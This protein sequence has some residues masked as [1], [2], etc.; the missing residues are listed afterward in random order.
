MPS[1][2]SRSA[3]SPQKK[4]KAGEKKTEPRKK[5]VV[6]LRRID[7]DKDKAEEGRQ[8]RS[9]RRSV[10]SQRDENDTT[11]NEIIHSTRS[12]SRRSRGAAVSPVA[13]P[14]R[15]STRIQE[16]KSRS[17]SAGTKPDQ[18]SSRQA[19]TTRTKKGDLPAPPPVV[20]KEKVVPKKTSR[21]RKKINLGNTDE[22]PTP[23][24]P[25][26]SVAAI[27]A[28]NTERSSPTLQ[29]ER[30]PSSSFPQVPST[31][32][33]TQST[34]SSSSSSESTQGPSSLQNNLESRTATSEVSSGSTTSS[35]SSVVIALPRIDLFPLLTD[36][37]VVQK[38]KHKDLPRHLQSIMS[39]VFHEV[40]EEDAS[41]SKLYSRVEKLYNCAEVYGVDFFVDRYHATF[42]H[43][44]WM[45]T[46]SPV[47]FKS[48]LPANKF[49]IQIWEFL[50]YC[51]VRLG[52]EMETE[53]GDRNKQK[54]ILMK[55]PKSS[56]YEPAA[57]Y[58]VKLF[59][60][61]QGDQNPTS[62]QC[63]LKFL[64]TLVRTTSE[65]NNTNFLKY[66]ADTVSHSVTI[67]LKDKSIQC[68]L[69]AISTLSYFTRLTTID[70]RDIIK[71]IKF[72]TR[73]DPSVEVRKL[74][75]TVLA[76]TN[77]KLRF[78][79]DQAFDKSLSVRYE[80]FKAFV[81]EQD[82]ILVRDMGQLNPEKLCKVIVWGMEYS[83]TRC[84]DLMTTKILLSWLRKCC[85]NEL[86]T[87][88]ARLDAYEHMKAVM[89]ILHKMLT[90]E[91]VETL[92]LSFIESTVADV[93]KND[94]KNL[95]IE[96]MVGWQVLCS[97]S[98]R[99][100]SLVPKVIP[101]VTKILDIVKSLHQCAILESSAAEKENRSEDI[102]PV[103]CLTVALQLIKFVTFEEGNRRHFVKL[104]QE[105]L[106]D[107]LLD[108]KP[109][110]VQ[111]VHTLH[112]YVQ[113]DE[114]KDII[115]SIFQDVFD[116]KSDNVQFNGTQS[117]GEINE[118]ADA[119]VEMAEEIELNRGGD[120]EEVFQNI[121][122]EESEVPPPQ[123]EIVLPKPLT[124][125][126][127]AKLREQLCDLKSHRLDLQNQK[128]ALL[129]E[130]RFIDAIPLNQKISVVSQQE[131]EMD[132]QL[133]EAL[134]TN[135]MRTALETN[136][137]VAIVTS[138][139]INNNNSINARVSLA[140]SVV[141]NDESVDQNDGEKTE[142]EDEEDNDNNNASGIINTVEQGLVKGLCMINA[143]M[144]LIGKVDAF[145]R[146]I[147]ENHLAKFLL[148]TDVS[149]HLNVLKFLTKIALADKREL[150]KVT[151]VLIRT[152]QEPGDK[153]ELMHVS[154]QSLVDLV[155]SYD[156]KDFILTDD[157]KLEEGHL[158]PYKDDY[159]EL[160][161]D[162]LGDKT[163]EYESATVQDVQKLFT[164]MFSDK[165]KNEPKLSQDERNVLNT[166]KHQGLLKLLIRGRIRDPK[167]ISSVLELWVN[168]DYIGTPV[169]RDLDHALKLLSTFEW[170]GKDTMQAEDGNTNI[171]MHVLAESLAE[172][173]MHLS[174]EQR[175]SVTDDVIEKFVTY[176][177]GFLDTN[178]EE[179]MKY[180]TGLFLDTIH[181][182]PSR[183]Y[184][185]ALVKCAMIVPLKSH[186]AAIAVVNSINE[187]NESLKH[188]PPTTS[189]GNLKAIIKKFVA[190]IKR[191]FG[192]DVVANIRDNYSNSTSDPEDVN[193]FGDDEEEDQNQGN[194]EAEEEELKALISDTE[195]QDV[196]M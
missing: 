118:D 127:I 80:A 4:E 5:P 92:D 159:T 83:D 135:A 85:N 99:I 3:K 155:V 34:Q 37:R 146:N 6:V 111:A 41:M 166:T 31:S 50:E 156:Y 25:N 129:K 145:V 9:A 73:Y 158:H 88:L 19:T 100:P 81:V 174:Q 21:P 1:L 65:A 128:D 43:N 20:E 114:Y 195:D 117:R 149:I 119:D 14:S 115:M 170:W 123:P 16:R 8:T 39:K 75:T 84:S 152:L 165:F 22:S 164:K 60:K 193:I 179:L 154:Y 27:P 30:G 67:R 45:M 141:E 176:I 151:R 102:T 46:T 150:R 98:Q 109:L 86:P 108:E 26:I 38:Q 144:D 15:A 191:V 29:N 12:S 69:K 175:D 153:S 17:T 78:F 13:G 183:S 28:Q 184:N 103:I 101:E 126:Q 131:L 63:Q 58:A 40:Q 76:A 182:K 190:K 97:I 139:P 23:T 2:R 140:Q 54:G 62:R 36:S 82:G 110:V 35:S 57:H 48:S 107:P 96:A 121:T 188:H 132:Q 130:K 90:E 194:D 105:V 186:E 72:Y 52:W 79:Y 44:L 55:R 167:V 11:E 173:V 147:Y 113:E 66:I 177:L 104:L 196:L 77:M 106:L 24:A 192:N 95:N 32:S 168:Y 185:D 33:S 89:K 169:L 64:E 74:G 94:Y 93:L 163:I 91:I 68:R 187:I 125:Y 157:E 70:T 56:R 171:Q 122:A 172:A 137:S 160:L 116:P 42:V 148:E 120:F 7:S 49:A 124:T 51:F 18:R 112:A 136:P 162:Y 189:V 47:V 180:L 87:F 59:T 10:T 61:T 138:P 134:S 71:E 161:R 53:T 133:Q 142:D 181:L 178:D 143:H